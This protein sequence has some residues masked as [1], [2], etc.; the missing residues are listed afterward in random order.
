MQTGVIPTLNK[1]QKVSSALSK[2]S[3]HCYKWS[4]L[5]RRLPRSGG[6]SCSRG[7]SRVWRARRPAGGS[8]AS[9][10]GGLSAG[11]R[12][13]LPD[14]ACMGGGNGKWSGLG[15]SLPLN[16]WLH[17]EFHSL[18]LSQELHQVVLDVSSR[19]TSRCH[20]CFCFLTFVSSRVNYVIG[21][22]C[23]PP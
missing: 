19:S 13:A 12:T 17:A 15:K 3:A 23:C 22:N 16:V 6:R 21:S 20:G 9:E 14:P 5:C 18:Y 7:R 8:S 4:L 10:S 1:E 11:E 2:Q